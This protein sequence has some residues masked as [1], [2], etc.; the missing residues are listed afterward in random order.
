MWPL[1]PLN[2]RLLQWLSY[3]FG[4][5][6]TTLS[7]I[8]CYLTDRNQSISI[9]QYSS[10][11]VPCSIVVPPGSVL[12]PLLFAIYTTSNAAIAQSHGVQQQQYTDD[13]QLYIAP[14]HHLI[15]H[16]NWLLLKVMCNDF[17][18][19]WLKVVS[20][21]LLQYKPVCVT[22]FDKLRRKVLKSTS[23]LVFLE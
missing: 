2:I 9:G 11:V 22:N 18:P 17:L 12:G 13:T 3:S 15:V 19:N 21:C 23:L 6:G 5:T 1:I 16:L 20:S 4:V 14:S 7:W 10:P 8:K